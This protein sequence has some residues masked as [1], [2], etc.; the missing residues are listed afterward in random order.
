MNSQPILIN[1]GC[2][3]TGAERTPR[4]FADWR[5]IRIDVD[6][7]VEPDIVADI[8]DLAPVPDGFADAIW[9]SHCLEHL[10][11]H[12]VPLALRE[13]HRVLKIDGF[14]VIL[15]PDIQMIARYV[16]ED[17]L[18]DQLYESPAGPVTPHDVLYGFGQAVAQG[19]V[20]MAHKTGFTPTSLVESL[21]SAGYSDFVIRRRKNFELA[22]VLR[23]AP[24][25]NDHYRKALMD[26]LT[27]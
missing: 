4:F 17:R 25:P 9:T 12:Q 23:K 18:T 16:A 1:A 19:H 11:H 26:A 13:F 20:H 21:S 14:A 5:H 7:K 24:W 10:Y 15:V 3:A 27:L 2:G 22:A 6:P 8:T